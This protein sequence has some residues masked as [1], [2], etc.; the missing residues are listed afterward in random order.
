MS[1]RSKFRQLRTAENGE[2][3]P[4]REDLMY[5]WYVLYCNNQDVERITQ[6]S[7]DWMSRCLPRY[8]K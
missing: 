6:E 4:I 1:T 2:L 5:E 8:I 7:R 3:M